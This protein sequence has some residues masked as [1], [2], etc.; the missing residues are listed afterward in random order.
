[1]AIR[2]YST[3]RIA[4]GTICVV[5]AGQKRQR[6]GAKKKDVDASG[7]GE[8]KRRRPLDGYAQA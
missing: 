1:L 7:I 4:E 6:V 2:Y 5:M 3:A 8:R